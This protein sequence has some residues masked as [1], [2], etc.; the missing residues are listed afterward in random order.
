M[1]SSAP[2]LTMS[3]TPTVANAVS[4]GQ[5]ETSFDPAGLLEYG[6][7][8]YWRVDEV[9]APPDS[10]STRAMSGASP[11]SPTPIRSRA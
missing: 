10:R 2:P 6:K 4:K 1:S 3:I 9:N 7:T 11:R 5:K 8:Y